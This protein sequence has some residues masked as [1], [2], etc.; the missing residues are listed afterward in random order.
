MKQPL[1][2][3]FVSAWRRLLNAGIEPHDTLEIRMQKTLLLYASGLMSGAITLWLA[4]YWLLGPRLSALLPIVMQVLIALNLFLYA[5]KRDF[6]LFRFTQLILFLFFPFIAQWAI[7]DFVAA[8]G[9]VLWGLIAPI[10]A[11]LCVG[12]RQA[13]PWFLAYL[14]LILLTGVV[15]YAYLSDHGDLSSK[16]P[17]RISIVFFALNFIAISTLVFVLLR[18]TLVERTRTQVALEDAHTLL[19]SEQEKSEGLLLNVLPAN[20]AERLKQSNETIADGFPEVTVMFADIVGFTELASEMRPNELF[21][22]L[23]RV[24]SHFDELA[25]AHGLEKI[26]TIGDAYMVAGGLTRKEDEVHED[27][28]AAIAELALDMRSWL[29]TEKHCKRLNLQVRIGIGTGPVVAGVVGKKKFIYDLWGDTVNLA[30]RI[31]SEG[32]PSG[33]QCDSATYAK[34]YGRY[35][36]ST[37]IEL[38]LKG[39]GK[40]RVYRLDGHIREDMAGQLP[41]II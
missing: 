22:I 7:G 36:F 30:S 8:S 3:L 37:P 33:I 4:I 38:R 31:S 20:I 2:N 5:R 41:T 18:Y 15:D 24:F 27:P 29:A 23:N 9:L 12:P 26:K 39:K 11:L 17:L 13:L 34:L 16:V 21:K 40:V 35:S 1:R 10:G 25:E 19:R 32:H 28:S 6:D 14:T